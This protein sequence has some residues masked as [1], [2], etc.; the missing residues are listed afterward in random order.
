[1][2]TLVLRVAYQSRCAISVLAVLL[3]CTADAANRT[4][5]M[6]RFH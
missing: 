4:A 5:Q 3:T 1:M 2:M 6:P